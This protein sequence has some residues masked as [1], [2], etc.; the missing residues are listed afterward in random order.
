MTEPRRPVL[1]YHGS[2]W[3][4]APWIINYFP[5]H[6][7]YVEPYCGGASVLMRKARAWIEVVN[8]LSEDVVNFFRVIREQ[9]EDLVRLIEFTPYSKREWEIALEPHLDP[10]ESARRF[11]VRSWL[12]IAGPTAQ[13]RTGW[14]RQKIFT[15][16]NGRRRMTPA[17]VTFMQVD[18]LYEVANRLRGV[19]IECDE[20]LDVITR[21]DAPATLFYI[22]PPYP[23][24]TRGRWYKAAYEYE[25]T[26]DQHG[27]LAR[28]LQ[29]LQGM[30][31][32]SGYQ[33]A[34]YDQLYSD[35][36]RVEKRVRTQK[37]STAMESLWLSPQLVANRDAM[38]PLFNAG[39]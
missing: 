38:L 21:Y 27:V 37:S 18:H 17:A 39:A 34:L 11:Y 8:D 26:D 15:R 29:D 25:M 20:A 24:S 14:R 35:W 12:S 7:C 2:K 33:C 5:P 30:A 10:V 36:V 31:V 3:R 9:P 28:A 13:W 22:D 6:D 23:A 16:E 19:Q 1:R 32:V 4:I